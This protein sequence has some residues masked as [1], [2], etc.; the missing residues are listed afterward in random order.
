MKRTMYIILAVYSL[1]GS[2]ENKTDC[3][4]TAMTQS[5]INRCTGF[6]NQEVKELLEQLIQELKT[7]LPDEPEANLIK[8]Q[9]AWNTV[10]ENDCEIESWYVEGGSARPMVVAGCYAEHSRQRVKMLIPLLCH[11]M[12]STCEAKE[13]YEKN[14]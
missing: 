6:K 11:P 1:N 2:A 13:K 3:Y 14:L 8:S 10:V 4:E 9:E 12:L 5:E 7:V